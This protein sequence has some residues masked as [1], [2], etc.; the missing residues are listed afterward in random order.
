MESVR[1]DLKISPQD[2][3]WDRFAATCREAEATG[4]F[5]GLWA[6]DHL[7]PVAS[8]SPRPLDPASTCLEGWSLLAALAAVTTTVRLG[9]LVSAVPYRPVT[10]L[11]K[12]VAT[13]D[14]I[15]GGRVELGLGAG[16]TADEAEAFGI[17]FGSPG[18]RLDDLDAA[19]ATLRRLFHADGSDGRGDGDLVLQPGPV[20]HHVPIVIGGKGERRTLPLVATHA[21]G[22]NYS[23][24][25]P[26]EFAAKRAV[27]LDLCARRDRDPATMSC[28]V[29]VRT[30]PASV[31]ESVAL[32]RAYREAGADHIVLYTQADPDAVGPLAEA[33]AA[34]RA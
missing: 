21:D 1:V 26:A 24:G 3:P 31:D 18:Q 5:E 12:I 23:R 7:A 27:L 14:H 16:N 8:G 17:P 32:A 25:T 13:V 28:S 9:L 2:T 11:A 30:T 33:A 10:V 34:V 22:W 20:Q 6:F 19:C 15:S 4:A 29:Q